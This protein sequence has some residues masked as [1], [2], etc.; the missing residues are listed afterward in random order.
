MKCGFLA[1][2]PPSAVNAK[3]ARKPV[4]VGTIFYTVEGESD[5]LDLFEAGIQEGVENYNR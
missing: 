1:I 3:N 2:R 4:R 5:T